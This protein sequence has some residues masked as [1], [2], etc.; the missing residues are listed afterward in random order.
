M[1]KDVLLNHLFESHKQ[2][3]RQEERAEILELLQKRMLQL[4]SCYCETSTCA[5]HDFGIQNVI[6]LI[7]GEQ[8]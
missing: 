6:A 5:Y 8:K 7:K 2:I 3:G 1:K 4:G